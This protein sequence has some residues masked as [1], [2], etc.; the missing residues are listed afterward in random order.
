MSKVTA[1]K[2]QK[3]P[4][5]FNIFIDSQ[6]AFG[7]DEDLIVNRRLLVGKN[8]DSAEL[9]KLIFESEVGKLMERMYRLFSVRARSEKE[10]RNYLRQLSYKRKTKGQEEIS[11]LA[12]DM[13]I[14]NL[15]NKSM[16]N[17]LEFARSWVESRRKSKQKGIN[18]LKMELIQK[19]INREIIEEA[20]IRSEE[21]GEEKLAVQALEKK[22]RIWKNLPKAEFKKKAYDF[23]MRRGFQWEVVKTV[24]EKCLK[25]G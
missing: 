18:S 10:V 22:I 17:D 23:L 1:V 25:L 13:L 7:A 4:H 20:L 5:R 16:V 24:V 6:F 12:A 19:G 9:E 3:N 15:K 11:D 21:G 2:P 8:I 14:N